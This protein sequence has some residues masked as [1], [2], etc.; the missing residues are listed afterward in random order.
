MLKFFTPKPN[1][2]ASPNVV[3]YAFISPPVL[4][5]SERQISLQFRFKPK[6]PPGFAGRLINIRNIY[7]II[8]FFL[9]Q[10]YAQRTN[11]E[12]ANASRY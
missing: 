7:S 3:L 4:I 5:Y 1:F 2:N 10:N 8:M 6:K 12:H 11:P 9:K